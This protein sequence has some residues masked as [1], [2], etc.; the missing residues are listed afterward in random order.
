MGVPPV[1]IDLVTT[2]SGV[3]FRECYTRGEV[4]VL[5][6]VDVRIISLGDLRANKQAAGRSK[7]LNDLENLPKP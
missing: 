1:C 6:G 5:D 3:T 7:D 2:V 4:K